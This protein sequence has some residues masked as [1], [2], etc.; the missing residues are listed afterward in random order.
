M[1]ASW[2]RL[3][4]FTGHGVYRLA[5]ADGRVLACN[6]GF[7][8]LLD[9]D[10]TPDAILGIPIATLATHL[11]PAVPFYQALRD[12]EELRGF[13]QH[14]R[15]A[16][17]IERWGE[18]CCVLST[19]AETGARVVDGVVRDITE[20]VRAA[21]ALR[22]LHDD[23]KSL[24]AG[25]RVLHEIRNQLIE[26]LDVDTFCRQAVIL[27]HD[28]LRIDRLSLW[29]VTDTPNEIV[30]SYGID[31]ENLP[32][33]ERGLR[34]R[35]HAGSMIAD[36]LADQARILVREHEPLL[37]ARAEVV[38]VGAHLIAALWDGN[39]V[40][41]VLSAD[42]LITQQPFTRHRVELLE[43]FADTLG[44]LY[45]RLRLTTALRALAQE[46][47][48]TEARERHHLAQELHDMVSQSLVLTHMRLSSLRAHTADRGEL[49]DIITLLAQT[50]EQT[51]TLTFELSPPILYELGLPA[52]LE[53]LAETLEARHHLRIT[54]RHNA[55]PETLD[56]DV[57]VC[58]FS[59]V[60]EVLFNVIK[61]ARARHVTVQLH[62]D[63]AAIRVEIRDDGVGFTPNLYP[64]L[65][66]N[67]HSFGLFSIRERLRHLGGHLD[68][69]SAPGQGTTV[70]LVLPVG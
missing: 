32:R 54:V 57:R 30:G 41:G 36:V 39:T 12:V 48:V 27:G 11:D 52:A 7:L 4:E 14:F 58:L 8:A 29:F 45:T 15:T 21:Q 25:L 28:R 43:L 2:F 67:T 55:R 19:D 16:S 56:N 44:H 10:G 33:D 66:D 20:D 5:L 1:D 49:D 64:Y 65:R 53:W 40:I 62:Q 70:T 51:R 63:T 23:E 18:H 13:R 3:Q 34:L 38:G 17:G 42:N 59:A 60:R 26:V 9:L 46:V 61:H 22:T 69:T 35:C 47:I 37:N 24:S 68:I 31:E 6:G 50:I